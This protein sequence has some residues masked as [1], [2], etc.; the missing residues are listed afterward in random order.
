MEGEVVGIN[1]AVIFGAQN[2]GFAI[3]IQWAKKDLEDLL[4][5]GRIIR[6]YIGL[7]YI[8]LN[9]EFQKRYKLPVDYGALIVQ[10]HAPGPA[11]VKNSPADKAG[12]KENDIILA[13]NSDK[14]A[15]KK[16]LADIIQLYKAGEEVELTCLRKNQEHKAK[17]LLEERK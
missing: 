2:I 17:V 16:D 6:P 10:S 11:V 8:M 13:V 12:I 5:F 15:E 1:T 4:K 7:R 3:P 14:L 9:K